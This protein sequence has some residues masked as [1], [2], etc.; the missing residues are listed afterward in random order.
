[1]THHLNEIPPEVERVIV[2]K[3][4]RVV[5]DG[6]KPDVL[7]SEFLSSVYETSIRITERDGYYL[8]YPGS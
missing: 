6:Q 8:A 2:L 3:E 5:A 7:T 1:V 4:G